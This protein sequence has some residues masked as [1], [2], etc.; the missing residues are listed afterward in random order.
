MLAL[1]PLL[2]CGLTALLLRRK[3]AVSRREALLAA[4]VFTGLFAVGVA[5][6]SGAAH[7]FGAAA[8]RVAWVLLALERFQE[9]FESHLPLDTGGGPLASV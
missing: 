3:W 4:A 8:V 5:E 9:S 1:L 7:L 6:L 2:C